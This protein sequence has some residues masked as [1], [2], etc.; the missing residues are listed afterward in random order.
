MVLFMRSYAVWGGQRSVLLVLSGSI[1]VHLLE[2]STFFCSKSR[3]LQAGV[4]GT[5]YTLIRYMNGAHSTSSVS[6]SFG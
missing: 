5:M 6:H 1:V 2:I 4:G 3:M